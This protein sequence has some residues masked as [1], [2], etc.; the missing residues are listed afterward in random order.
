MRNTTAM[1]ALSC[2]KPSFGVVGDPAC[3]VWAAVA[4]RFSYQ[5][6]AMGSSGAQLVAMSEDESSGVP[7]RGCAG[8]G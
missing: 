2:E 7:L 4:G 8:V 3:D 1:V 6:P 5:D